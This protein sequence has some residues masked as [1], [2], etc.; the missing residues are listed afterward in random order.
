MKYPIKD[1][2]VEARPSS[3][4]KSVVGLFAVRPIMKGEHV[5][6]DS[7]EGDFITDQEFSGLSP[8]VQEKIRRFGV[9]APNGFF[10]QENIDFNELT[11]SFFINHSCEPNLGFDDGGDFFAL[12]DITGGEE[13]S[14][15]YGCLESR[16]DFAFDCACG[17][18]QCRKHITGMDWLDPVFRAKHLNHMDPDLRTVPT[19]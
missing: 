4:I 3:I 18:T 11:I 13:F 2:L 19:L 10:F 15:D 17:S 16:P 6:P 9:G 1:V 7:N 14:Y 8:A 12:R 5:C